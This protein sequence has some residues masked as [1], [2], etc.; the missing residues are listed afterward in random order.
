MYD[1]RIWEE[2]RH[3]VAQQKINFTEAIKREIARDLSLHEFQGAD[4]V[5]WQ[6]RQVVEQ[7]SQSWIQR[8]YNFC[9][10]AYRSLGKEPSIEFDMAVWAYC[11]EPFI[12]KEEI[13]E[14]DYRASPLLELLLCAVGSPSQERRSLRVSQKDCCLAVR[15][16]VWET[17][18]DKLLHLP[19]KWDQAAAAMA[20]YNEIER[21]ARSVVARLPPVERKPLHSLIPMAQPEEIKATTMGFDPSQAQIAPQLPTR[22]KCRRIWSW[23]HIGNCG[24]GG[25]SGG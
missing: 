9:C 24:G 10:N 4:K 19:S 20:R 6:L 5:A 11:I 23:T 14:N 7:R 8:L 15:S 2:I 13:N 3:R 16:Q 25:S 22:P 21:R 17:W 1:I 12:M 18:R